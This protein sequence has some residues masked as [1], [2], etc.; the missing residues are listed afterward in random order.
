MTSMLIDTGADGMSLSP[1]I[2]DALIAAG[3]ASEAGTEPVTFADGTTVI[4]RRIVINRVQVGQH[5]L[6]SVV[7]TVNA[8]NQGLML[9]PFPILNEMGKFTID[10]AKGKLIFGG[11]TPSL[12]VAAIPARASEECNYL[13]ARLLERGVAAKQ[14]GSAFMQFAQSYGG[15]E[16]IARNPRLW[17]QAQTLDQRD[18]CLFLRFDA[19]RACSLRARLA[20]DGVAECRT[21]RLK[22]H[23]IAC[24]PHARELGAVIC[25]LPAREGAMPR[26]LGVEGEAARRSPVG[27]SCGQGHLFG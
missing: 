3:D 10:T 2:A 5:V 24:R 4:Q 14:A 20:H 13:H 15:T 18:G 9:L 25:S 23:S 7:A 6:H 19:W 8:T 17:A 11:S 22:S 21:A 16:V 1:A 26:V 12:D 27:R